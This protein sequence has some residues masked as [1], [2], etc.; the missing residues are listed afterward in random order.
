MRYLSL[1]LMMALLASAALAEPK[2]HQVGQKGKL[3]TPDKLT[4]KKGDTV[5]F[6]NDDGVTHNVFSRAKAYSFNLK[7][8]R[9]GAKHKVVFDK[10]GVF[11]IRCAIHPTMKLSVT[12]EP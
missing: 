11:K 2:V 3:F 1:L 6:V 8:Q 4:I 5:E 10:V 9:P 7:R 12:V